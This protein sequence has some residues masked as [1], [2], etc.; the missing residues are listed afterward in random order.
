[1]NKWIYIDAAWQLN[2]A[3][4]CRLPV[5]AIYSYLSL[6]LISLLPSIFLSHSLSLSLAL[7][8]S[9]ALSLLYCCKLLQSQQFV[10]IGLED[11][12]LQCDRG[13]EK[14][15]EW[16]RGEQKGKRQGKNGEK[17]RR[18][19]LPAVCFWKYAYK[20]SQMQLEMNL[21]ITAFLTSVRLVSWKAN[22]GF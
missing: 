18:K 19:N 1:M 3:L 6:I 11:C 17:K 13:I 4:H 12:E 16:K 2:C 8:S 7:T 9:L 20:L 5:L 21:G 14:G 22:I 15:G 10:K